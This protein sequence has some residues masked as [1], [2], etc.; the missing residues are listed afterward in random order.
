MAALAAMR[1]AISFSGH[2]FGEMMPPC[3]ATRYIRDEFDKAKRPWPTK[4]SRGRFP[5]I[6]S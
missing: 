1:A 4:S 6:V 2:R 5:P 3:P